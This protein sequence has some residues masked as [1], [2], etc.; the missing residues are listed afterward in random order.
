MFPKRLEITF[1]IIGA[2]AVIAG[3]VLLVMSISKKP[4]MSDEL[5]PQD[6]YYKYSRGGWALFGGGLGLIAMKLF[7][8]DV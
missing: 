8:G 4:K 5:S 6:S 1:Y 3:I 7:V 2:I